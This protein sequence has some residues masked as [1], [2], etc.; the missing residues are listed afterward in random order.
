MKARN[1]N[2]WNVYKFVLFLCLLQSFKAWFFWQFSNVLINISLFSL[3]TILY[4]SH[5]SFYSKDYKNILW[6][7]LLLIAGLLTTT[8]KNFNGVLG[9]VISFSPLLFIIT[10]KTD[11]K[12]D[13]F[14]S[15]RMWFSILLLIS[16]FGWLLFLFGVNL[17]KSTVSYGEVD[18]SYQ[19]LY[20]NYY[21]FLHNITRVTEVFRF[22]SVFIEPGYLGCLL[23]VFLF[24]GHYKLNKINIVFYLSLFFTF[25][26]A[27]WLIT[28]VGY[29]FY[30]LKNTKRKLVWLLLTI[31]LIFTFIKVG[32]EYNNGNN[33]VNDNIISRMQQDDDKGISGYNRS[34]QELSSWFWDYFVKSDDLLLGSG[35]NRDINNVDW[36]SYIIMHGLISF[37][38]Y[39]LYL[40]FP[41]MWKTINKY[42]VLI[43][44]SIYTLI[45]AQTFHGIFWLFYLVM[46]II[47]V[48]FNRKGVSIEK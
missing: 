3:G 35:N 7:I 28:V 11:Y 14:I 10:L 21:L 39:F 20:S 19:Y 29:I 8:H 25:S 34:S 32:K 18:G 5:R 4:F 24:L 26:L 42:E 1:L 27:G 44:I 9:V 41:L 12:I 46:F 13:L 37:I 36:K 6:L 45:F 47:G 38:A 30:S 31:A 22:S 33:W 43:L 17:T 15:I 40:F 23:S 2:I 16:L 48:D